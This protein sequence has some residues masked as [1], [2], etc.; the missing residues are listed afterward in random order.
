[1]I[2]ENQ[3]LELRKIE[4]GQG[5]V[6]AKIQALVNQGVDRATAKQ[7]AAKE[8]AIDAKTKREE[9]IKK[10]SEL[11]P[12]SAT[13]GRLITRGPSQ[14][15]PQQTLEE[16]RQLRNEARIA[17]RERREDEKAAREEERNKAK[18]VVAGA[19]A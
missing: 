5:K 16:I 14:S 10:S 18:I 1:M 3:R 19:A 6:A 9:P 2:A 12:L 15:I 17:A 11:S 4:I 13:E 8:A 7:L